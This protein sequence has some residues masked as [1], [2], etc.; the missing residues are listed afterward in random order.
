MGDLYRW[1]DEEG[2][3]RAQ[4]TKVA[5]EQEEGGTLYLPVLETTVVDDNNTENYVG[6]AANVDTNNDSQKKKSGNKLTKDVS[7]SQI[8]IG[9]MMAPRRKKSTK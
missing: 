5:R 1:A 2:I 7:D 9:A 4:V 6:V 3:E 8:K